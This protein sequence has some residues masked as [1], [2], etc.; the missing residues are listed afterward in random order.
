MIER[1]HRATLFALY[2][3]SLVLGIVLMPLAMVATRMGLTLPMHKI[4]RRLEASYEE[5]R[6]P[7]A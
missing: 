3:M 4:L 2:Q 6:R 5:T 1:V 7:R